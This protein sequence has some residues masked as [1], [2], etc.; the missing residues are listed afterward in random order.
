GD[1]NVAMSVYKMYAQSLAWASMTA[2]LGA[3]ALS[4]IASIPSSL[5]SAISR[6]RRVSTETEAFVLLLISTT[7][8]RVFAVEVVVA[9]VPWLVCEELGRGMFMVSDE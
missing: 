5:N 1:F 4:G 9:P 7:P 3:L 2:S 8:T 6:S